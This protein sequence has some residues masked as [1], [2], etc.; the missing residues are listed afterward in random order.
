MPVSKQPIR[1]TR[2]GRPGR[3]GR[4][5]RSPQA[6]TAR[7]R[8][9]RR[10]RWGIGGALAAAAAAVITAAAVTSGGEGSPP[11][12]GAAPQ[13]GSLAPGGSFTAVSGKTE[14]IGSL[15][16]RTTLLWLVATWCPGCQAGTQQLA[17]GLARLRAAGVRVVELEDYADLG[18]PGPGIEALGRQYAGAAYHDPDWIFGTASAALTRAWNPQGY[19]DIYYLL[20]PAGHVV[21]AGSSPGAALSQILSQA[22][23]LA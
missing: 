5:G 23:R 7:R 15:R 6:R 9:A 8:R 13:A 11:A 14:A 2:P 4:D 1:G 19:L 22:A 16:G 3:A 20:D 17:G 21:S 12:A 18:Q 10:L